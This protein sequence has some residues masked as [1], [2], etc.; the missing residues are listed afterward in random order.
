M[1]MQVRLWWSYKDA[2]II[3]LRFPVI[4]QIRWSGCSTFSC[5][6]YRQG[7]AEP[8]PVDAFLLGY[9]E[10]MVRAWHKVVVAPDRQK[11]LWNLGLYLFQCRA[12]RCG[13]SFLFLFGLDLPH[14][15]QLVTPQSAK[16][17]RQFLTLF[18]PGASFCAQCHW[19][20]WTLIPISCTPPPPKL[21]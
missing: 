9:G 19:T 5:P 10:G 6:P 17:P 15:L 2:H 18:P 8:Y 4:T 14:F 11:K 1:K 16:G 13:V 7:V 12:D 20:H 3:S 21:W